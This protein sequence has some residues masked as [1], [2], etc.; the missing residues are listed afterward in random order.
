MN[1]Y[2]AFLIEN[3]AGRGDDDTTESVRGR[4]KSNN[5]HQL[6]HNVDGFRGGRQLAIGRDLRASHD[7]R[8]TV[9]IHSF[10]QLIEHRER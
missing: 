2:F 3:P 7:Q 1:R 10:D 8:V 6:T 9:I 4:G 5:K